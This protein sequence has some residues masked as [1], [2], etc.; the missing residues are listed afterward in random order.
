MPAFPFI[1]AHLH[2]WDPTRYR[3]SWLDKNEQLNHPFGLPEFAEAT[4]ELALEAMVFIQADVEEPYGLLETRWIAELARQEPRI[5]AIVAYAPLE[6]GEQA[7]AYLEALKAI[8]PRVKGVRRLLQGEQDPEFCLRPDFI[9]ALQIL[10]EYDF[11]FDIC[12]THQQLPAVVKMVQRCPQ[13]AFI[14]DHCGK[15]NILRQELEPWHEHI[16]ELAGYPNVMCKIS[17]LVT[18]ADLELWSPDDLAPYIHYALQEFGEDRVLFGGD[19]PVLTQTCSYGCW[20]ETL[21]EL[22]SNLSL[23]AKRKLWVENARAFYRLPEE[24]L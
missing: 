14:L 22:T 8:D 19:W 24:S 1:D 3:M 6:Y 16:K 5:Q 11:S 2:I 18:E 13:T 9:R 20:I 21:D 23:Q 10:P 12:V 17:G 4:R 15:P 7:R